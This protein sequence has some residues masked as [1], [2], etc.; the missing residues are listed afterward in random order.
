MKAA[1][2]GHIHL[3]DDLDYE[4]VRYC[5]NGAVSGGWWRGPHLGEGNAGYTMMNL[6]DDGTFDR[7]YVTYGWRYRDAP[8]TAPAAAAG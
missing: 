5:C 3:L 8:A 7:E 1:I 6:Y 4:S 2:S